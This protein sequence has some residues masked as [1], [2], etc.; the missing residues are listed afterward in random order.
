MFVGKNIQIKKGQNSMK[1]TVK[2]VEKAEFSKSI[3]TE[4]TLRKN[5]IG[6]L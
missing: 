2:N 1:N 6:V 3:L 4:K 5:N